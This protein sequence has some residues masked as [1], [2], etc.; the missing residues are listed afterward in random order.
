MLAQMPH[1]RHLVQPGL[2]AAGLDLGQALGLLFGGEF[3]ALEILEG[4][5]EIELGRGV[6][7]LD[8]LERGPEILSAGLD[9]AQEGG[10]AP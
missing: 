9:G 3:Q 6:F 4:V 1:H 10:E 7:L 8:V 2:V 5:G